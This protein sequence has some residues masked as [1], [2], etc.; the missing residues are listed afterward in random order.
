MPRPRQCSKSKVPSVSSVIEPA[1]T[2]AIA[3]ENR[4]EEESLVPTSAE[5]AMDQLS[6]MDKANQTENIFE[7]K[8][9]RKIQDLNLK[10]E[11][12]TKEL[13]QLKLKHE[14]CKFNIEIFKDSP[15]DIA[16]LQH[17]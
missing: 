9:E 4:I 11:K 7:D 1:M 6:F 2:A 8:C 10:I 15:A 14:N 5:I 3:E 12:I 16:F 13:K 17:C